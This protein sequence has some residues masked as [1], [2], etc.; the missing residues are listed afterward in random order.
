[1]FRWK[2]EVGC[3]WLLFVLCPNDVKHLKLL[4]DYAQSKGLS[5]LA[6]SVQVLPTSAKAKSIDTARAQQEER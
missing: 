6:R 2:A 3:C 1:V 5:W 4:E